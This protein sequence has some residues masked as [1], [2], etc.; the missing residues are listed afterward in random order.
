[1]NAD[2]SL[3]PQISISNHDASRWRVSYRVIDEQV[4]LHIDFTVLV[5]KPDAEPWTLHDIESGAFTALADW[6]AVLSLRRST[7]E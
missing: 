4:P 3:N 1:M 2:V 6:L 7:H 5:L